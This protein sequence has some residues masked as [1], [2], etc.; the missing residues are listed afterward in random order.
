MVHYF[1]LAT[2]HLHVQS[3][4]NNRYDDVSIFYLTKQKLSKHKSI[5]RTLT[6]FGELDA[7]VEFYR[8][9][10]Q[11]ANASVDFYDNWCKGVL[12]VK[13][14]LVVNRNCKKLNGGQMRKGNIISG[15]KIQIY[16]Q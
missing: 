11:N 5:F 14:S 13:V 4:S 7:L 9:A 2:R 10:S 15:H 6:L 3:E 8:N 1:E 16:Y 12:D